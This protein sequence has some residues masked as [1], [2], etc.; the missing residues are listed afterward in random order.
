MIDKKDSFPA[1]VAGCR[2]RQKMYATCFL[3]CIFF[4]LAICL[5]FTLHATFLWEKNSALCF[6]NPPIFWKWLI[7][8]VFKGKEFSD[9]WKGT[10]SSSFL[11]N[12]GNFDRFLEH[13]FFLTD[14]SGHNKNNNNGND[15]S[16][17]KAKCE[18][19]VIWGKILENRDK[20]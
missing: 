11:I 6:L 16:D 12:F 10:S 17:K 7:N 8:N 1:N 19:F 9:L 20:K 4:A 14:K 3:R 2:I 13:H 15:D 5:H 18:C